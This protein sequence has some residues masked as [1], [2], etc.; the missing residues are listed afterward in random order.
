[1]AH[2]SEP[3]GR[4]PDET[5]S[6]GRPPGAPRWVKVFAAVVV[7]LVLL[8]AVMLMM[9]GGDHGPGRHGHSEH[10]PQPAGPLWL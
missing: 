8:L 9:G 6:G 1:M 4:D 10:V 7:A 2:A 5:P 3:A